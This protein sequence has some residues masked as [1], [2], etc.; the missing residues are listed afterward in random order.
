[1]AVFITGGHGH[2]GSWTAYF[3]AKEG[4]RVIIY[5]TQPVPPDYLSEVSENI[6]FIG[7]DVMDFPGLTQLFRQ[8]GDEIDGIIHTVALMGEFVPANPYRNV[9]LNIGGLLNML[10]LARIFG[11]EKVLYTSTGAV[12]GAADGTASE[13]KNPPNP[14]DL[15]GA[16]KVSCEY[17]GSQYENTMDRA[18]SRLGS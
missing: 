18:N 13:D 2:I 8:H 15:Y 4:E 11:I 5:D 7:G 14:V 3:L 9:N 17:L 10:E 1:M 6:T 16:T 12:Y